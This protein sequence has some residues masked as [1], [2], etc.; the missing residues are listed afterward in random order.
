MC[1]SALNLLPPERISYR[2]IAS[3]KINYVNNN[4]LIIVY[5]NIIADKCPVSLRFCGG[6]SC[7][8]S[9]IAMCEM[10]TVVLLHAST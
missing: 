6:I 1:A 5:A 3:D 10:L 2:W 9:A 4:H 8:V 7:Y